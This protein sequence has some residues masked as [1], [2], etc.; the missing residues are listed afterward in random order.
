MMTNAELEL[1]LD[2]LD[3]L[4]SRNKVEMCAQKLQQEEKSGMVV[5]GLHEAVA[6]ES[7]GTGHGLIHCNCKTGCPAGRCKCKRQKVICNRR[8]HKSLSCSNN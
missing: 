3:K 1:L 2:C 5:L 4:F 6:E 7:V 8:C